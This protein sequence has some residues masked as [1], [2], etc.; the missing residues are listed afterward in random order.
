[1]LDRARER[2]VLVEDF[3]EAELGSDALRV[4]NERE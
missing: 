3:G 2:S 1:M 4:E